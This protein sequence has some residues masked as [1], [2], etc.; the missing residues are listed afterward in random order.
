MIILASDPGT[1]TWGVTI[2]DITANKREILYSNGWNIEDKKLGNRM[3]FVK[4]FLTDLIETYKPEVLGYELPML[5]G[6]NVYPVY[7]TCGM[8]DLLSGEFNLPI[9]T[10]TA[11][12]MKKLVCG[13]AKGKGKEG[14]LLVE[15]AARKYFN[16][17]P[18]YIYATNHESDSIGVAIALYKHHFKG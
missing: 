1:K 16:I 17:D 10:V 5:R 12:Q 11:S 8:M 13:D 7:V 4:N 2:A 14:K 9:V 6:N 15:K 3:S 18:S